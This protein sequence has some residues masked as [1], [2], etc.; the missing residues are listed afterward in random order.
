MRLPV[1]ILGSCESVPWLPLTMGLVEGFNGL[2]C[3]ARAF[4]IS[5][6][7]WHYL[8]EL[9]AFAPWLVIVAPSKHDWQRLRPYADWWRDCGPTVL[10]YTGDDPYDLRTGLALARKVDLILTPEPLAV[11]CYAQERA[12]T[13][14]GAPA[15]HVDVP[16]SRTMHPLSPW[17]KPE[18]VYDVFWF[19]GTFWTP[20]RRLIPAI[21]SLVAKRGGVYGEVA[22]R[23][24]WVAGRE[25]A[26]QLHRARITL[27]LPRF[28]QPTESNPYQIPCT[29]TGPR[30]HIAA[31]TG[32]FCLIIDGKA[33][34]KYEAFPRCELEQWTDALGYWLDRER[35]AERDEI[36]SAAW[37]EFM[38]RHA[39]VHRARAIAAALVSSGQGSAVVRRAVQSL[40]ASDACTDRP[41]AESE[42][43]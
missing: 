33:D 22:G 7:H 26:A 24:R 23:T 15:V 4:R 17:P 5:D 38:E 34:G 43:A 28:S 10:G 11:D 2:G 31:A 30:V 13:D 19:G 21:R 14:K 18:P 40:L 29:W 8:A 1:A 3:D 12:C 6:N 20:R 37:H 42:T 27:E 41:S 39:P 35:D 16:V 9:D 36:A 32:T 25:L